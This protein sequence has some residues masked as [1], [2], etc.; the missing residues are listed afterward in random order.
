VKRRWWVVGLG[1]LALFVCHRRFP[2][3]AVLAAEV[4]PREEV[5]RLYP[6]GTREIELCGAEGNRLRGYFVPSDAGAPV[7]LHLLDSSASCA[8]PL[9]HLGELTAQLSDLGWASLVV[10]YS[11]VGH[12]QGSRSASHLGADARAAWDAAVL[13]AGAPGRVIVRALSLGTLA[14]SLLLQA[15]ARPAVVVLISPVLPDSVVPRFAQAMFGLPGALLGSFLFRPAASVDPYEA[16]E[17][18]GVPCSVVLSREDTLL[19]DPERRRFLELA[20]ASGGM[21]HVRGGSHLLLSIEAR[22]LFAAELQMYL[23]GVAPDVEA[24]ERELFQRLEPALVAY[25]PPGSEARARLRGLLRLQRNSPPE[26]V[27]AAALCAD[28][29]LASARWLWAVR[30]RPYEP[31]PFEGWVDVLSLRDPA[32]ALAIDVLERASRT[33]DLALR[34]GC[35][36]SSTDAAQIGALALEHGGIWT[37]THSFD[38]PWFVL[39][40]G[41]EV[42]LEERPKQLWG[43]IAESGLSA[44]DAE[45]HFARILLKAERIPDCL[46]QGPAG[47]RI[48][49][50]DGGTWKPVEIAETEVIRLAVTLGKPVALPVERDEK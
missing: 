45:R 4:L 16:L 20:Q 23:A 8:S 22:R 27:A 46:T 48:E 44:A 43:E 3:P 37:I 50:W 36:V 25:F 40:D 14:T 32:G 26:F 34:L 1:G 9:I 19:T 33:K 6:A 5:Y 39:G 42:R 12:S 11:G 21:T 18:A 31:L 15:G 35:E 7:V 28:D 24:R 41:F 30:G 29:P 49:A 47:A 2:A 17:R 10:D 13:Q 38:P